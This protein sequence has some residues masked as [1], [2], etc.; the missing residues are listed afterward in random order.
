MRKISTKKINHAIL[1]LDR[2]FQEFQIVIQEDLNLD[3][4]YKVKIFLYHRE[5][6]K[7]TFFCGSKKDFFGFIS[8]LENLKN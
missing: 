3:K 1:V 7:D 4:I 6:E 5:I 8:Y 2:F